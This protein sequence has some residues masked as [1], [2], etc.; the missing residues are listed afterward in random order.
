MINRRCP[1]GDTGNT[2]Q[3]GHHYARPI[4]H[5]EIFR[6]L[7]ADPLCW[8]L[9]PG[10]DASRSAPD[11]SLRNVLTSGN[12]DRVNLLIKLERLG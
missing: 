4:S 2:A 8:A 10:R 9:S 7:V 6:P 12:L 11:F 5:P 1:G 3:S